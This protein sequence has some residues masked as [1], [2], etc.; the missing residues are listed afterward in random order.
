MST[1]MKP[2]AAFLLGVAAATATI[3]L[4]EG[5]VIFWWLGQ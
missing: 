4:V 5:A 3:A 2:W 1:P